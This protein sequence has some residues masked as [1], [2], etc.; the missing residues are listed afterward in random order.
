M[1]ITRTSPRQRDVLRAMRELRRLGKQVSSYAIAERLGI[2]RQVAHR[3][4]L[5][6]ERKGLVRDEPVLVRSGHWILTEAGEG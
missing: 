5:A 1:S 2:A 4:L 3:H 6:L